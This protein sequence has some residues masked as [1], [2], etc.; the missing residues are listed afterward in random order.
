M[1]DLYKNRNDCNSQSSAFFNQIIL[2]KKIFKKLNLSSES[3]VLD[4]G[5]GVG[6]NIE[7]L[8][9]YFNRIDAFDISGAAIEFAKNRFK[10]YNINFFTSSIEQIELKNSLGKIIVFIDDDC[11]PNNDW[12]EAIL[13]EFSS[14]NI[15][16]VHGKTISINYNLL[17]HQI[18]RTKNIE[19]YPTCNMAYRSE[20]LKK[21]GGF[22]KNFYFFNEDTDLAWRINEE[23]KIIFSDKCVVQHR[24]IKTTL[25]KELKIIKRLIANNRLYLKH[26]KKYKQ[27][28]LKKYWGNYLFTQYV[29]FPGYLI[30]T[31]LYKNKEWLI[32]NP[33]IYFVRYFYNI[34]CFIYFVI[35]TPKMLNDYFKLRKFYAK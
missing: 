25:L 17:T 9:R 31:S 27:N 13:E 29:A 23:Y 8:L 14:Q 19:D 28:R 6:N 24:P 32:R 7:T 12:L 30:A 18:I 15:G 10:N 20:I 11:I 21:Y 16:G 33:S 2:D 34:C 4:V 26:T 5:C 22:D 3:K 35:L 1:D